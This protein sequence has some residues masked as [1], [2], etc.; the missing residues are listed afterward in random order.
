MWDIAQKFGIRLDKLYARNNMEATAQVV[1]GETMYLRKK[2]PTTPKTRSYK[3][4]L[5]E[6]QAIAMAY[7]K[8]LVEESKPEFTEPVKETPKETFEQPT[9]PVKTTTPVHIV[10]AGDTLYSLAL[11]YNLTV[12]EIKEINCLTS[13]NIKPGQ[14]LKVVK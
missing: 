9:E 11:R 4:V 10:Q 14:E 1:A 13:N 2:N 6:K 5:E 3:E 8:A 12:D 7:K